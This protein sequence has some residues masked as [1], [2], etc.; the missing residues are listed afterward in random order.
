[1]RNA[2]LQPA[3]RLSILYAV[4]ASTWIVATDLAVINL[5]HDPQRAAAAQ[6]VKGWL[7]VAVTSVLLY[8][9][10]RKELRR[11]DE[12]VARLQLVLERMPV[13]CALSDTDFR[14]TY[15]NPA[16]EH[17]FGYT[18]TEVVGKQPY[19]MF[20]PSEAKTYVEQIQARM[21]L[22]DPAAHGMNTNRTR[23]GRT[24]SCEWYNTPLVDS[25]GIV[26]GYLAMVQDITA[27]VETETALRASEARYKTLFEDNR[28]AMLLIDP[29]S[30]Q[31]AD[32]NR[33]AC[34]FY[35]YPRHALQQLSIAQMGHEAAAATQPVIQRLFD[36]SPAPIQTRHRLADE[37]QRDVEIYSGPI[38]VEGRTL[39]YAIVYDVTARAQ[40]ERELSAI[41]TIAQALRA[42]H[43]PA[44]MAPI[45]LDY[46]GQLL[47]A[48]SAVIALRDPVDEAIVIQQGRGAWAQLGGLRV[49]VSESASSRLMRS[50][51]PYRGLAS[52]SDRLDLPYL[53]AIE[54][55]QPVAGVPLVA[56]G[57]AIGALWA[58]R[59]RPGA[60]PAQPFSDGEL[61]LLSAVGDIA[62][63]AIT[64]A[65]LHAQTEL[66]LSR[67]ATLRAIDSVI[68][69]SLDLRMT[70]AA[71]LAQVTAQLGVESA[72]VLRIDRESRCLAYMTMHEGT[73]P[74]LDPIDLRTSGDYA[75]QAALELR[76]IRVYD[77]LASNTAS[78]HA[79]AFIR[80][81][82]QSYVAVPLV[83]RG[84]LQGVLEVAHRAAL[85]LEADWWEYLET[86]ASQTAIAMDNAALY[87]HLQLSNIELTRAYD[88]TLA[89][90]AHALDLRDNETEGHSRRVTELTLRLAETWGLRGDA[91]VQIRRGAL[92]HDI[93]KLGV[94]DAILHKPGP[95]TEDEWVIMRRH[96]VYA[97]EMLAPIP[98]LHPALDIPYAH[99]ERWNGSGYPRGLSGMEI[100]L[101]ARLFAV[102]DVWDALTSHRPYRAAWMPEQTIAYLQQE[103]GKLFD[104][105]VVACF[106]T[107]LET[108][109]MAPPV[110]SQEASLG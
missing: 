21:S 107:L 84:E 10:T 92:L 26:R 55:P 96:T 54:A 3:L 52:P 79:Q 83:A 72:A 23:D 48:D 35:G 61:Q 20:V 37:A 24:I 33:A 49:P 71:V 82:F 66:Q 41:A 102:V 51:R 22:G 9:S 97:Y 36:G 105:H 77:L 69:T 109:G 5:I 53:P 80:A 47:D 63:N 103:S 91:L 32:A 18:S 14:V 50:G 87:Q 60:I 78:L 27:R 38:Q 42:A 98:Y 34:Q 104:P 99:H 64:R 85:P 57:I 7:F 59:C 65:K 16:A 29:V 106:L 74:P 76:T 58:G 25:D 62:A 30:G 68:T 44:D 89:G 8:R 17:I 100:P 90:W 19:E 110:G 101:P 6:I 56:R 2:T 95:L 73:T 28:A 86:L 43:S 45:I 46:V 67:L 31:I 108:D 12:I 94:P 15:W 1:M 40:R 39:I 70:L 13:G 81:G 11:R 75:A 4:F 88:A 93:G